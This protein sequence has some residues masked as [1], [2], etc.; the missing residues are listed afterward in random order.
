MLALH[1]APNFNAKCAIYSAPQEPN[2][3]HLIFHHSPYLRRAI[4]SSPAIFICE[5]L[6][7]WGKGWE[8]LW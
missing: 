7:W 5:G 1:H 8:P 6:V 3:E 2:T 4:H